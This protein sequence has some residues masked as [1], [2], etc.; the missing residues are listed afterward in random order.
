MASLDSKQGR[1]K[2]RAISKMA[3]DEARRPTTDFR[4]VSKAN[5]FEAGSDSFPLHFDGLMQP[6]LE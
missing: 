5:T 4:D 1:K 3:A 6:D 2:V